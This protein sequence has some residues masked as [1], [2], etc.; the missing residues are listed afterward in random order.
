MISGKE[1]HFP[2]VT[3][4]GHT[5]DT[6]M[7]MTAGLGQRMRPVTDHLPKPLVEVAGKTMLDRILDY[8]EGVGV[9]HVVLNLHY[10]GEMIRA[11]MEHRASPRIQFSD[12]SAALLETGGGVKKALPLLQA[13]DPDKPFF[14]INGDVIWL[15]GV[16]PAL[17]HLAKAWDPDTMDVLMLVQPTAAAFGYD[18]NGDFFM[19]PMG[20]LRRRKGNEIAPY[21]FTGVQI[22]HP[23]VF[24]AETPDGAFSLNVIYNQA[25]ENDRLRAWAHDGLFFHVGTPEAMEGTDAILREDISTIEWESVYGDIRRAG[26][27]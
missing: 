3:R 5:L 2:F 13:D 26:G 24:D 15:D 25:L 8:L 1:T 11:H 18:G 16:Y 27:Q 7:V 17:G 4:D 12:E 21:L 22:I 23:R 19:D 20:R 6:A 10:L 9:S 14:V